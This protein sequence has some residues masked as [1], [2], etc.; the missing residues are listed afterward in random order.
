[1]YL[2]RI[3]KAAHEKVTDIYSGKNTPL[4]THKLSW[5]CDCEPG[6]M[7]SI[8]IFRNNNDQDLK[9]CPGSQSYLALK[10][11]LFCCQNYVFGL[12][13]FTCKKVKTV[14]IGQSTTG[15]SKFSICFSKWLQGSILGKNLWSKCIK[16]KKNQT[17]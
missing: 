12:I 16:F 8:I 14:C 2:L 17:N 4:V 11:E 7:I 6:Q 10:F 1:M 3:F 5:Q 9:N 13:F 15:S